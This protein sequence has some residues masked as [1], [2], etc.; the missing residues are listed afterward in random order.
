MVYF[1]VSKDHASKVEF[2]FHLKRISDACEVNFQNYAKSL[3]MRWYDGEAGSY[4][5]CMAMSML[6]STENSAEAKTLADTLIDN[7]EILDAFIRNE[8][9]YALCA[10]D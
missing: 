5:S 10:D 7:P 9:T 3:D 1:P 6:V 2:I 4:C 8:T